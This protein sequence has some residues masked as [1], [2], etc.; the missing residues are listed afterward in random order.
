MKKPRTIFSER[1]SEQS[2]PLQEKDVGS[3]KNTREE[4]DTVQLPD[5]GIAVHDL[6]SDMPEEADS[7]YEVFNLR[8]D[9]VPWCE[10]RTLSDEEV[11]NEE[12]ECP[13]PQIE[14]LQLTQIPAVAEHVEENSSRMNRN[15]VIKSDAHAQNLGRVRPAVLSPGCQVHNCMEGSE[16]YCCNESA[17][18]IDEIPLLI[19]DH[20]FQKRI[21]LQEKS[22]VQEQPLLNAFS[23]H[24]ENSCSPVF[25]RTGNNV[26]GCQNSLPQPQHLAPVQG[27][28]NSIDS[29]R[30]AS[31]IAMETPVSCI[32]KQR[33]DNFE[34]LLAHR[35]RGQENEHPKDDLKLGRC[36]LTELHSAG[37]ILDVD[38]DH[39]QP[40]KDSLGQRL[41]HV[42]SS[43]SL[44]LMG[45]P[46]PQTSAIADSSLRAE[47][48]RDPHDK[49]D[50]RCCKPAAMHKTDG[51]PALGTDSFQKETYSSEQL[52]HISSPLDPQ[53]VKVERNVTNLLDGKN[54]HLSRGIGNND[55]VEV[56]WDDA[57]SYIH[58]ECL[59]MVISCA[60]CAYLLSAP[61]KV[62][63]RT[64]C[65]SYLVNLSASASEVHKGE[66]VR[67]II[68][69]FEFLC[70]LIKARLDSSKVSPSLASSDFT[71][72]SSRCG[73]WVKEDGCVYEQINCPRCEDQSNCVGVHIAATDKANLS[74]MD[75]VSSVV[76][77]IPQPQ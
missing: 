50:L 65:K 66:S 61:T 43:N 14:H 60:K 38:S 29:E 57:G 39:F 8:E 55:T 69:E 7:D 28:K 25:E 74:L 53:Q 15:V 46:E 16:R 35:P 44:S 67:V 71:R 41:F 30:K 23:R 37:I 3:Q 72:D 62:S 4:F 21:N 40:R 32:T 54:E 1:I 19:T 56:G 51:V 47:N 34:D 59:E 24:P 26:S 73:V 31:C 77:L 27:L 2:S 49:I 63:H 76:A 9:H 36:E 64:L 42:L 20:I 12:D 45:S 70:S 48:Y 68:F 6:V 5:T 10:D 75:T 17:N 33:R 11:K 22:T 13:M 18:S 52:L 58:P